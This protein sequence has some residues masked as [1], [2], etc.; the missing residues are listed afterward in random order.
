MIE[1]RNISTIY[2]DSLM[3]LERINLKVGQGEFVSLVGPSGAGKSTLLRLLTREISPQEGEVILDGVDL[4]TLSGSELPI[5]R[6]KIGTVYQDFKLLSNKN[7]YENVAF[8]LEV[9][10]VD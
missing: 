8:A 10:V 5:L 9:C 4:A 1:L 3:A 6:R 7:A 2:D